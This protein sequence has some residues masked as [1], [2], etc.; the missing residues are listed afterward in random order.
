MT[1][2]I[3][4]YAICKN[5][6]KHIERWLSTVC[7]ADYVV[8]LDT[9][10]T[11][12]CYEKLAADP[13]VTRIEQKIYNPWRFDEARNDSMK[14]VPDD[15]NILMAVDLDEYFEPGW[16]KI[17]RDNWD[18]NKYRRGFYRMAWSLTSD[19]S[20]TNMFTYDKIHDRSFYWIFPVHE[21]LT[22]DTPLTNEQILNFGDSIKMFHNQDLSKPRPYM[23]LLKLRR[24]E[25]PE[26]VLGQYLLAREYAHYEDYDNGLKEFLK[27]LEMPNAYSEMMVM[28]SAL[29]M[30]GDIYRV[31]Q[32]RTSAVKYYLRAI[33]LD[34][35]YR[36]AYLCIGEI[37][38]E[39]GLY[40]SAKA[41]VEESLEKSHQHFDWAER[42]STWREKAWDVLSVSC[43]FL[44]EYQNAVQ[45]A[46]KALEYEP[47][48]VRLNKNYAAM[49]EQYVK[50]LNA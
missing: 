29:G 30:I 44:G 22:T 24:D 12:G 26:E 38:N 14:L 10:S 41:I 36:E 2:K 18:S 31:K 48:D 1:N 49:L 16:A 35:S 4:V 40:R 17:V 20:P 5:E 47:N 32:D 34:P 21:V 23:D 45:Y 9:G 15:A 39:L 27:M 3:C 11:D 28:I 50:T 46:K 19:G 6:S 13:R 43:F 42:G 7:E 25:H 33:E 37:Y 8:I